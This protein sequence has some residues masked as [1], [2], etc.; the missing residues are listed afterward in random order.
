MFASPPSGSTPPT[1]DALTRRRRI[2]CHKQEGVDFVQRA[3]KVGFHRAVREP[4]DPFGNYGGG[5]KG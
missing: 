5:K 1:R 2:A 4:D 3:Q